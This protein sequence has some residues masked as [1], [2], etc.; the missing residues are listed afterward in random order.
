MVRSVPIGAGACVSCESVPDSVSLYP[1]SLRTLET[2]SDIFA[3][4]YWQCEMIISHSNR[5]DILSYFFS[6]YLR[7]R[8]LESSRVI[9]L[10]VVK[11]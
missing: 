2:S 9:A 6:F 4:S 3:A 11:R 5:R 10:L 7:I 1:W 8:R